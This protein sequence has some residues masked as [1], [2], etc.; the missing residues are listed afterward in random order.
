MT[1][2]EIPSEPASNSS[3]TSNVENSQS[4]I[5]SSDLESRM[6][7]LVGLEEEPQFFN[8]DSTA[9]TEEPISTPQEVQTEQPLSS[10]PFAKVGV[11]GAGTLALVLVAG[12]VLSQIMSGGPG[13]PK[14]IVQPTVR[15]QPTNE[16]LLKQQGTEIETLKT[17]L[18]LDQQ[19]NDVKAA[20]EQLRSE[21]PIPRQPPRV[22]TPVSR[23]TVVVERVP[24]PARPYTTPRI[25]RVDRIARVPQPEVQRTLPSQQQLPPVVPPT[26]PL[27]PP[28]P[29]QEWSR[30]AKLG[31]Y[32]QAHASDKQSLS[33][34]AITQPAITQRPPLNIQP[35]T[36][37]S[38]VI[39]VPS[40]VTQQQNSK[41]TVIGSSAR[42]KLVTAVYGEATQDNIYNRSSR[43]NTN[44]NSNTNNSNTNNDVFVAQLT[45]P[46]KAA[47]GSAILPKDTQLLFNVAST[48]DKGLMQLNVFKVT[49]KDK[50]NRV[51]KTVPPGALVLRGS[52]GPALG[53]QIQ[54]KQSSHFASDVKTFLLGGAGQIGQDLNRPDQQII[55]LPSTT[56]VNG[57][58]TATT[59]Q[60]VLTQPRRDIGASILEGGGKAISPEIS[61]RNQ[62]TAPP[63]TSERNNVFIIPAG[64]EVQLFVNQPTVL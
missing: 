5:D 38:P 13:K 57:Q 10:N 12:A 9:F 51:E 40:P 50:G 52:G 17:K 30:L 1:R 23:P 47:D 26:P 29:L 41:S 46:L 49:W 22:Q 60:A 53:Q 36:N 20:Q 11:V 55:N 21:K 43:N 4:R 27:T 15:S 3:G 16:P 63:R 39:P 54:P 31:S 48:S 2:Y 42:A 35:S 56:T 28:D 19:A 24:I 62:Q 44:N 25:V 32:G 58:T 33:T 34:T 7:R 6:A 45:E 61:R 59:S 37:P 18:A 8:E 14:P 64:K